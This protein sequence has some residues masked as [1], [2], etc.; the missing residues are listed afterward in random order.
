[1]N[2]ILLFALSSFVIN[3]VYSTKIVTGYI[4]DRFCWFDNNFRTLDTNVDLRIYPNKHT[5][6]CMREVDQCV[7]SGYAFVHQPNGTNT[8][9]VIQYFLD[10][11]GNQMVLDEL[12]EVPDEDINNETGLIFTITGVPNDEIPPVLETVINTT[13][14][15]S[16]SNG[17]RIMVGL[18]TIVGIIM[19]FN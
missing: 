4:V 16:D 14:T 17:C 13:T 6:F 10:D 11:I 3:N 7:A 1:M 12:M 8:S 18:L 5:V 9:Y 15:E 2:S 19:G